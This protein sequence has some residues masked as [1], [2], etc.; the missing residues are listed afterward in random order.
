MTPV[1]FFLHVLT[2]AFP[3]VAIVILLDQVLYLR[4]E[5][6]KHVSI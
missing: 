2:T 5:L 4:H 6:E 1:L 3:W